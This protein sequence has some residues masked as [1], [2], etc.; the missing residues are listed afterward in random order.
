MKPHNKMKQTLDNQQRTRLRLAEVERLIKEQRIIVPPLSRR[1]LTK[2]CEEGRFETVGNKPTSLG[3]LVYEDSFWKWVRGLD[4]K[5]D[6][7]K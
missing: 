3:W 5:D 6:A 1:V 2:M 4:Q 7:V